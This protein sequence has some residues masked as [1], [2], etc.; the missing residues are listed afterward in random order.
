MTGRMI[1][2]DSSDCP[3]PHV[4]TDAG[5]RAATDILGELAR[6]NIRQAAEIIDLI[7][8]VARYKGLLA[9]IV[10]EWDARPTGEWPGMERLIKEARE[11]KNT[12]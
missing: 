5:N 1:R 11:Y 10:D 9:R 3:P 12:P 6:A 2:R 8:R 7:A 4:E